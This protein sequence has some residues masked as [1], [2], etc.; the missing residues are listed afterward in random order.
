MARILL[1]VVAMIAFWVAVNI[2]I[3]Y[4]LH[5][6]GTLLW[7]KESPL[8]LQREEALRKAVHAPH[9]SAA[10]ASDESLHLEPEDSKS[11][12]SSAGAH[13]NVAAVATPEPTGKKK[14]KKK[15]GS[16]PLPASIG[17]SLAAAVTEPVVID[18]RNTGEITFFAIGDWGGPAHEPQLSVAKAMDMVA[19]SVL[20]RTR[21]RLDFIVSTGDNMYE[22]GVSSV[23]DRRFRR[24]FEDVYKYPS[25]QC[26]W[27]MSLGN[28]D[29]GAHGVMRDVQA[30]VNYT[31]LSK[32]WFLPS[33]YYTQKLHIRSRDS[34]RSAAPSDFLE[35]FVI[36]TYDVSPRITRMTA[37]QVAWLENALANSTAT[38]RVV[39][40]HRPLFSA[41]KKHGSSPYM[42]KLLQ[43]LFAKYKVSA[44]LCGDDHE[45]QVMQEDGV[46]YLLSGGGARA[47]KD[48]D[49]RIPQTVFHAGVHGFMQLSL[50][51]SHMEVG[52]F[53]MRAE[54]LHTQ[55]HLNAN[56]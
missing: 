44:Y 9:A 23:H 41:G 49:K 37:K 36:D 4:Q 1:N 33:T 53:N 52:V 26:R 21:R 24:N 15:G 3:A 22:D 18:D 2:V 32:R 42:Q 12:D 50:N 10:G 25:Q 7:R 51:Q 17:N 13:S 28:H 16:D 46:L 47:K 11:E 31:K 38:W 5:Q 6:S 19:E 20:P 40:G 27:Y 29:H 48:L 35:L 56:T 54:L 14:K 45:L 8:R 55:F 30:E 39:V 43:P 34:A